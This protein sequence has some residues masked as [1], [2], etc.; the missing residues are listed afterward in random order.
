MNPH[1]AFLLSD[2]FAG[3]P[4]VRWV[5]CGALI[6]GAYVALGRA[7]HTKHFAPRAYRYAD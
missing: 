7:L 6:G 1:L 2:I 4:A 3:A 5:V